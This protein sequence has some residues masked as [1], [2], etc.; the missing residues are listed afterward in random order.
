MCHLWLARLYSRQA[1]YDVMTS[2]IWMFPRGSGKV[3]RRV[4]LNKSRLCAEAAGLVDEGQAKQHFRNSRPNVI[5]I[6]E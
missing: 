5:E 4:P 3:C 6:F 2:A 1:V